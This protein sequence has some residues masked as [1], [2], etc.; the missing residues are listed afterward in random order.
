[1]LMVPDD[2]MPWV[3]DVLVVKSNRDNTEVLNM[4]QEDVAILE[5]FLPRCVNVLWFA[6]KCLESIANLI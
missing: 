5:Q 4:H 1:M 2:R 3:G 6:S